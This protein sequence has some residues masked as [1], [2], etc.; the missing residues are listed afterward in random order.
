[1]FLGL[2][3]VGAEVA[4]VAYEKELYGEYYAWVGGMW[5]NDA[6]EE[7][8]K[9]E[10]SDSKDDISDALEGAVG[11]DHLSAKHTEEGKDFASRYL[12]KY[13][14]DA[15][16]YAMYTYDTVYMFANTLNSMIQRGDD[17]HNGKDITDGLR[18]VDF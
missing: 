11:L 12:K 15:T 16:T 10:Y 2:H 13:E 9:D 17:F 5:L 8:V 18:A 4:K 7:Y 3:F 1:V 14:M 6:F